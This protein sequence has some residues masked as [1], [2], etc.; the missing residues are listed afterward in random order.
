M[1]TLL[2]AVLGGKNLALP[3]LNVFL[4]IERHGIRRAK[5]LHRFGHHQPHGS[6]QLEEMI[7][8]ILA[9]KD[10]GLM[11]QNADFRLSELNGSDALDLEKLIEVDIDAVLALQFSIGR[12]FKLRRGVLG[13]LDVLYFNFRSILTKLKTAAPF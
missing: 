10:D 5:I 13:Y 4:E 9:G 1:E 12:L 3:I 11:V 8:C 7:D 2:Q 6:T